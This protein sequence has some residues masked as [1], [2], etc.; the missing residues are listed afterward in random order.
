MEA[1]AD[2]IRNH[3]GTFYDPEVV[4]ACLRIVSKPDFQFE[5]GCKN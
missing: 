1:A 4:D 3:R 2:E 5:V